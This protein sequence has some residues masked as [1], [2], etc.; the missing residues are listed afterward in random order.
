MG[1][2]TRKKSLLLTSFIVFFVVQALLL[3]QLFFFHDEWTFIYK[4]ISSPKEFI[5]SPHNG[6][7]MP[8]FNISYFLAFKTFGLNYSG[9]EITLLFFHFLNAYLLFQAVNR[10]FKKEVLAVA[11]ALIFLFSAVYW[12][13]LFSFSTFPTVLSLTLTGWSL[14][15]FLKWREGKNSKDLYFSASLSFLACLAWGAGLLYPLTFVA[16]FFGQRLFGRKIVLKEGLSFLAAQLLSLF[17]YR[18][19]AGGFSA[20]AFDFK[21]VL[22]FWATA[23]KWLALSFYTSSPGL[24]K[25]FLVILIF[26]LVLMGLPLRKD[27]SRK[28]IFKRLKAQTF[29][30]FFSLVNFA[31]IYLISAFSRYRIDMA[32]SQSSRYT[33]VPLFFFILANAAA[34]DS[35]LPYFSKNVKRLLFFYFLLLLGG[36]VYFFKIY[37]QGW[38]RTISQPNEKIFWQIAR[39]TSK[40]ERE[41]IFIPTTFHDFYRPEEIYFISRY[42]VKDASRQ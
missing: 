40:K 30:L 10:L 15:S 12:E 17:V 16:A 28:E 36:N 38:L 22:L 21:K 5:F 34:L 23:V 18:M 35:F 25:I 37:Y 27:K 29:I 9:Y 11:S 31:G 4:I 13:V 14:L 39:T 19:F 7:F 6:H 33:Y 26:F 3:S 24:N 42:L 1:N 2:M 20:G 8:L 32:L 41:K